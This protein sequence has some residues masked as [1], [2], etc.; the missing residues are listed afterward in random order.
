MQLIE[1][2][3]WSKTFSNNLLSKLA[4]LSI[5]SQPIFNIIRIKTYPSIIPFLIF[6]YIFIV[7]IWFIYITPINKINFASIP[8]K[9]GH[10]SWK[11]LDQSMASLFIWYI[12][13]SSYW[14]LENNYLSFFIISI[15]LFISIA[16]YKDTQTWGSLWCWLCNVVSIYL[17]FK[18]F[19]KNICNV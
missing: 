11:W 15:F 16:L 2:F 10:L 13:L 8:S 7:I 18:V 14:I 17:I 5:L 19:Q 3:I 12:F 4:L 9:N 1:Y 6:L